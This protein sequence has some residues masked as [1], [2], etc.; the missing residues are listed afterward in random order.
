MRLEE[1]CFFGCWVMDKKRFYAKQQKGS[2]SVHV[3]L[4]HEI[5]IEGGS[6]A[7]MHRCFCLSLLALCWALGGCQRRNKIECSKTAGDRETD[8]ARTSGSMKS[9]FANLKVPG[10]HPQKGNMKSS[11]PTSQTP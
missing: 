6:T 7:L 8:G 3:D 5:Q 4:I 1:G 10:G 9:H 2:V 11:H